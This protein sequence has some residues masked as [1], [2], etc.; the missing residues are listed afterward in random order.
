MFTRICIY[1]RDL[2]FL[3]IFGMLLMFYFGVPWLAA[4][5]SIHSI[6]RCAHLMLHAYR[7]MM[8]NEKLYPDAASFRPERFMVP[9]KPE[10]ERKMNPKN[11]VFGFGRR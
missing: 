9:T 11:F 3:E 4:L 2:W 5:F 10:M 7:A 6:F 8:R 1:L